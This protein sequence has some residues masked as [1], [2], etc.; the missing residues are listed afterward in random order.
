M[1]RTAQ[2]LAG[3]RRAATDHPRSFRNRGS[4]ASTRSATALPARRCRMRSRR[5]DTV[6]TSPSAQRAASTR[7]LERDLVRVAAAE[8][9]IP[10]PHL[11]ADMAGELTA[12]RIATGG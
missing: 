7:V 9:Q 3:A 4:S 6:Q 5:P 10:A 2:L 12:D 11:T 1:R 8:H